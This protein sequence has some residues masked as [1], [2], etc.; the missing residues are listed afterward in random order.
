MLVLLAQVGYLF[1]PPLFRYLSFYLS[2]LSF[3]RLNAGKSAPDK[4]SNVVLCLDHF[5]TK[6]FAQFLYLQRRFDLVRLF[7]C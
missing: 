5:V 3:E 7:R 6:P 4:V 1:H 2:P